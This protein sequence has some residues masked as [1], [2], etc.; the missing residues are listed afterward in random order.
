MS[1]RDVNK[2]TSHVTLTRPKL[3]A[4]RDVMEVKNQQSLEHRRR[5]VDELRSELQSLTQTHREK[6]NQEQFGINE[7]HLFRNALDCIECII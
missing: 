4:R 2:S 1:Q 6:L 5:E 7:S 3:D